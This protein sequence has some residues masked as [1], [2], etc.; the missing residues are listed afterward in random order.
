MTMP[1]H[2]SRPYKVIRTSNDTQHACYKPKHFDSRYPFIGVG[3]IIQCESCGQWWE[4]YSKDFGPQH[5][6]FDPP[7]LKWEKIQRK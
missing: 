2:D 3:T 6:P 7:V 5:D 1:Q 4:C